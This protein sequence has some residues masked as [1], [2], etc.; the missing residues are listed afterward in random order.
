MR[1]SCKTYEGADVA[2]IIPTKDRPKKI[3]SLLESMEAQTLT[4]G[5]IIIIDGGES[6]EKVVK[7]FE[8]LPVEHYMCNPPGQIRQRN[9]GIGL[10]DERT[11]LVGFLDDD[12]ILEPE[13]FERMIA[14]WNSVE[15]ET[16]GIGFNNISIDIP[17]NAGILSRLIPYSREPGKVLRSGL[18][19]SFENVSGNI[20]TQWLGGGYT[21][22]RQDIL[23]EFTQDVLNTRWATGEDLRFSYPIGKI[24]PLY[25]CASAKVRHEHV[26]DQFPDKLVHRFR[27]RKE[28]LAIFYFVSSHQELSRSVCLFS[29]SLSAIGKLIIGLVSLNQ[30]LA[31]F[32]MGRAEGVLICLGSLLGLVDLRRKMED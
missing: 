15:I 13:A 17:G 16:A 29:L 23:R 9:M 7:E 32:S 4:P 28:A 14:F 19:T 18:N 5:R 22:W 31:R 27:G 12:I 6:V 26:Y 2:F 8:T 1:E 10:L 11:R 3:R 20:R 21:V 30:G 24:H 25:V